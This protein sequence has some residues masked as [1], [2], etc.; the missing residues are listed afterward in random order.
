MGGPLRSGSALRVC[1]CI[2]GTDARHEA[3]ALAR[4]AA[5]GGTLHVLHVTDGRGLM[6]PEAPPGSAR[7]TEGL[8]AWVAAG[9]AG[10]GGTAV[11]L[12]DED[13]V[14]ATARWAAAEG[15][16][17][18]VAAAHHGSLE[19]AVVGSFS[20]DLAR[21][22]PCPVLV[23]RP[24]VAPAIAAAAACVSPGPSAAGLPAACR[25]L[26]A[27]PVAVLH[28]LEPQGAE[29][30]VPQGDPRPAEVPAWLGE[31]AR[32]SGADAAHAVR[33]RGPAAAEAWARHSAVSLLA[34]ATRDSAAATLIGGFASYLVHHAPCHVLVVPP[35][36][37]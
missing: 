16:D 4:A 20:A 3:L 10:V 29:A 12:E 18:V 17:L 6:R 8:R 34:V 27:D 1:C 36:Q 32:G 31:V 5:D 26:G 22:A 2:D 21:A 35:G 33:G 30:L 19:R 9:A 28:V 7:G 13:A 15:V 37:I 14:R 25:A 11:L 23:A 24:G